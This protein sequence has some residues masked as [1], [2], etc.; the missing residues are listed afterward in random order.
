[1]PGRVFCFGRLWFV[2]DMPPR[3]PL[4]IIRLDAA[5][6]IRDAN[7]ISLAYVYFENDPSR[8]NILKAMPEAEAKEIAQRIA[9]ALSVGV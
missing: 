3:P 9:T 8:A 5:F 4:R 2:G 7:G 6:A 1:M